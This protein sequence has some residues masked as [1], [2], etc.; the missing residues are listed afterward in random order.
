MS[1]GS[2]SSF[3]LGLFLISRQRRNNFYKQPTNLAGGAGG[4]CYTLSLPFKFNEIPE[5]LE[6]QPSS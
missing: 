5:H 2:T 3:A 1:A 4:K 6:L